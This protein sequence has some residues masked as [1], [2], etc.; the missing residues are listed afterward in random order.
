MGRWRGGGREAAGG[1]AGVSGAATGAN[2]KLEPEPLLG[3]CL[4]RASA[5][6]PSLPGPAKPLALYT[7]RSPPLSAYGRLQPARASHHRH[8]H[9]QQQQQATTATQLHHALG[10]IAGRRERAADPSPPPCRYGA[11]VGRPASRSSTAS[12]A[13]ALLPSS[14]SSPALLHLSPLR[15]AASGVLRRAGGGGDSDSAGPPG[16]ASARRSPATRAPPGRPPCR[17]SRRPERWRPHFSVRSSVSRCP[18]VGRFQGHVTKVM[19][20]GCVWVSVLCSE[21]LRMLPEWPN[22]FG[23]EASCIA[24]PCYL[25]TEKRIPQKTNQEK[26][27]LI[28]CLKPVPLC[29]FLSLL[30]V[31]DG[32]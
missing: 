16:S 26:K 32:L 18:P 23:F 20:G 27:I 1:Q 21:C 24:S 29:T 11:A 19:R 5:E 31:S 17:G 8:H 6:L 15:Q 2:R 30:W 4:R 13:V 14:S 10:S 7:H 22:H 28:S 12:L 25:P 9:Q 3:Q